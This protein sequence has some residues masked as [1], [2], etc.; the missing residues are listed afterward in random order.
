[1]LQLYDALVQGNN[2][3]AVF[4]SEYKEPLQNLQDEGIDL[5]D[6]LPT[7]Q[8]GGGGWP[9]SEISQLG[10]ELATFAGVHRQD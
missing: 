9:P 3:W 7:G 6:R 5:A 8:K 2:P 10:A 4:W 1:M